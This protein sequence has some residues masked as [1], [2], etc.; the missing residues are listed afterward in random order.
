MDLSYG[1]KIL[2]DLS[3]ILSQITRLIDRRTDSQT[4]R[5]LIARPRVHCMQRGEN[6]H[7]EVLIAG[8]RCMGDVL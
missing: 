7:V 2:T 4:E 1:I 3:S 6:V 5:I 8:W